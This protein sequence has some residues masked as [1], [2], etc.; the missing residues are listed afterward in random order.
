MLLHICLLLQQGFTLEKKIAPLKLDINRFK[1]EYARLSKMS[2][3]QRAM[4]RAID[5]KADKWLSYKA[6]TK[7]QLFDTV[8]DN[9]SI[10]IVAVN[11]G[12]KMTH[13]RSTR[14]GATFHNQYTVLARPTEVRAILHALG[15]LVLDSDF[16]VVRQEPNREL[17]YCIICER[18]H[19]V[20]DFVENKRYLNNLSYACKQSIADAKR[21]VWRVAA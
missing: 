5:I 15:F 14:G 21:G 9:V 17:R 18:H 6:L 7:E 10:T 16:V 11:A 12:G 3:F 8:D 2:V 19:A 13:A 1:R 4:D 20:A